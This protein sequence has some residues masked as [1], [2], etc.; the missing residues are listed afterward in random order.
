MKLIAKRHGYEIWAKF[1][2]DAN[3]YELFFDQEAETYTGWA[4]DSLKDALA[5]SKH[6]LDESTA[7]A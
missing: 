2:H 6:I 3:V 4:T 1:D 7:R 5:A